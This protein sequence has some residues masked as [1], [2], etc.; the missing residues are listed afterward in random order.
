MMCASRYDFQ[1]NCINGMF[2][3]EAKNPYREA[4]TKPVADTA[5]TLTPEQEAVERVALR[6]AML[7]FCK[8]NAKG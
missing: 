1:V 6:A 7:T 4:L 2:S 8:Q 3:A 5:A